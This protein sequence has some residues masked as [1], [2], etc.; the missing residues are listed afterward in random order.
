[1]KL[2]LSEIFFKNSNQFIEIWNTHRIR[3]K[4]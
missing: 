2:L 3:V 1:M 4:A